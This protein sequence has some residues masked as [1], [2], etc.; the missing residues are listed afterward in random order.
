[1]TSHSDWY[2][3]ADEE[4]LTK[5]KADPRFPDIIALSR[6]VNAVYFFHSVIVLP[7]D[8]DDSPDAMRGRLNSYLFT[9]ATLHEALL[10]VEKMNKN[11]RRDPIYQKGLHSLLKDRTAENIK[12][13]H[14]RARNN[15]I[16][17]FFPESFAEMI[18]GSKS[19]SCR[20]IK[21][22]GETKNQCYFDYADAL[23]MEVLVGFP[24]DG[25]EF[26]AALTKAMQ[27]T[28]DLAFRFGESAE[29]LISY[30]LKGWGFKMV[31]PA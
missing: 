1:M 30:C 29:E 17:H 25:E 14:G 4:T 2:I 18:N 24:A 5:S 11:F 12:R 16:F 22:R 10:L 6:A 31:N 19:K 21:A 15:V 27:A 8:E 23:A 13:A 9:C 3:D 7:R 28:K 26:Y 20:F